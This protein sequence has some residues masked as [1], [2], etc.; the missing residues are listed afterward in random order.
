MAKVFISPLQMPSHHNA[1]LG[2]SRQLARGGHEC[3]FLAPESFRDFFTQNQA[4]LIPVFDKGYARNEELKNLERT[5]AEYRRV[6]REV[7]SELL[8][9]LDAASE[10]HRPDFFLVDSLV[11]PNVFPAIGRGIGCATVHTMLPL[12][13][14]G[15]PPPTTFNP[16]V[17]NPWAYLKNKLLWRRIHQA[18]RRDLEVSG[19]RRLYEELARQYRVPLQSLDFNTPVCFDIDLPKL[20]L[21]AEAFDFQRQPNASRHYLGPCVT[22]DREEPEFPWE[23]L[24]PEQKLV[25]CALGT[26]GHAKHAGELIAALVKLME[27]RQ[28]LQLVLADHWQLG[29]EAL[30]DNVIK[31][32]FAP[33]LGLLKKAAVFVTHGGLNSIKE[34][35]VCKVPMLVFPSNGDQPGNAMRVQHHG[36][37]QFGLAQ[38]ATP[39]ALGPLLDEVMNDTRTEQKMADM[40]RRFQAEIEEH[41]PLKVFNR[42]LGAPETPEQMVEGRL[43][44]AS[45]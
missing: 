9:E 41:L 6:Y 24:N 5:S 21:C 40:S 42:L 10:T 8:Q 45:P 7:L 39:D 12:T 43:S 33:Q 29:P 28:D 34:A 38:Q 30:P 20:I 2:L 44:G 13:S 19:D 15:P 23:R 18:V 25:Y 26:V 3:H 11:V 4:S 36:L 32:D 16:P 35:I 37:G 27:S 1:L 17:G 22:L 31:V 14:D